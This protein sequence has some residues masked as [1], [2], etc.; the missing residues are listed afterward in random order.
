MQ[1]IYERSP[2]SHVHLVKNPMCIMIGDI[3]LRVPPGQSIKYAQ[4]L[5]QRGVEHKLLNYPG[6]SH[7]INAK[8]EHS[9][10]NALNMALWFDKHIMCKK[11]D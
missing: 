6:E 1:K 8:F 3:D 11:I 10:D 5:K 7:P 2:I 4:A 9:A